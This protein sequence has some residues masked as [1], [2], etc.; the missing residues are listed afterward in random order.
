MKFLFSLSLFFLLSLASAEEVSWK[1]QKKGTEFFM[2]SPEGKSFVVQSVGGKP[3]FIK[4]ESFEKD[5]L[6]VIYN[7]GSAGTSSPII[8]N[9]ALLFKK[10]P[11]TY[12]ADLPFSYQKDKGAK[13]N[14]EQPIWKVKNKTLTVI[15]PSTDE[16]KTMKLP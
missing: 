15:D 8:V 2:V 14:P 9:R 3:R 10:S 11:L 12:M 4:A 13:E 16:V 6:R 7:A 1:V 5:Y